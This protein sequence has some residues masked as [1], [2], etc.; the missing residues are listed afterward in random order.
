MHQ[1]DGAA[2]GVAIH[3]HVEDRQEHRDADG[4]LLQVHRFIDL[5][6]L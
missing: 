6:H 2:D 1:L 5:G 4:P 3:V